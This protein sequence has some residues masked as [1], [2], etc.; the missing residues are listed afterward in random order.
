MIA[1]PGFFT[2][3]IVRRNFFLGPL[4]NMLIAVVGAVVHEEG[5]TMIRE[6]KNGII[7]CYVFLPLLLVSMALPL[8]Q[9]LYRG[10]NT[11]QEHTS[12]PTLAY[13]ATVGLLSTDSTAE[14]NYVHE[15]VELA[16]ETYNDIYGDY[17]GPSYNWPIGVK[18]AVG[19]SATIAKLKTFLATTDRVHVACHGEY[20]HDTG[21]EIT[22]YDSS[23]NAQKIQKWSC[24]QSNCLLVFFS[25]CY[26]LGRG[27]GDIDN[28]LATAIKDRTDV[29]MV[30]G[31]SGE[32][33]VLAATLLAMNFWWS[34]IAGLRNH[35]SSGTGWSEGFGGY[36]G[37]T[38]FARARY[39]LEEMIEDL[40]DGT[41]FIVSV[42]AGVAAGYIA[43]PLGGVAGAFLSETFGNILGDKI[44]ASIYGAWIQACEN[45]LSAFVKID[46]GEY[47]P[48][49]TPVSGGGSHD[50]YYTV[51]DVM[52]VIGGRPMG[53]FHD[54][55][56]AVD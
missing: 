2:Q 22:L 52:S 16:F 50:Y 5:K 33:D 46:N 39:L 28:R 25:A 14:V 23:L 9:P 54:N 48:S 4:E 53:G 44:S 30:I 11:C 17:Y 12:P 31:Y 41:I 45:A 34:H 49:L 10:G 1:I 26:S 56:Y 55:Y 40:E 15:G 18:K 37:A 27:H 3:T 51:D 38:S 6:Y 8:V 20:R 43:G 7:V 13:V 36:S 35:Y 29:R 32:V 47:V 19:P 21:P 42:L 24:I